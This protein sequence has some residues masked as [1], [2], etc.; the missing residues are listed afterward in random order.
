MR[1]VL[2]YVPLHYLSSSLPDVPVYGY[3]MMLFLAFVLCGWLAGRLARREGIDTGIL[4]DMAVVLFI[5]GILGARLTFVIQEWP[6]FA[7]NWWRVFALWDGG[8]VFYG[9]IFG[10]TIGYIWFH[11][12]VLGPQR[13]P[14]WKMTDV[15][16]PCIALGLCLG[17]IGCLL[18][19]CCYGNVA[20]SNC[21]AISF[22]LPSASTEHM[23]RLGY[24]TLAGF[25]VNQGNL[26]VHDI[27]PDSPAEHAGLRR[28]DVILSVNGQDV[29]KDRVDKDKDGEPM[30]IGRYE[31]LKIALIS[32]W[33]PGVRQLH[34]KV[35]RGAEDI[36]L[37]PFL[38]ESIGL[39]PTQIYETISMALLL[40]FLLSY[41]PF[42]KRD[43]S[44]LVLLMVGYGM[45]R[46]LNEMLRIDNRIVALDMT[47][48]QIVSVLVLLGAA[49]IAYLVFVHRPAQLPKRPLPEVKPW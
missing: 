42:K 14:F 34:L 20:C 22:P 11:R 8:L 43:G 49:V 30:V 9:S 41:Y 5:T 46:F 37:P 44:V 28:H 18:T 21:P 48:S 36:E 10:G 25:T 12:R 27:E 19:G 26:E 17:R 23:A 40:F 6:S 16:A 13:V 31:Q 33:P 47:F 4:P 24:Q 2:F 45:H 35:R 7:G 39:H 15:V 29:S 38:P 3:G 1:Q 32:H